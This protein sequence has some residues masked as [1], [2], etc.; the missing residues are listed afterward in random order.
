MKKLITLLLVLVGGMTQCWADEIKDFWLVGDFSS[1]W[2]EVTDTYKMST[3]DGNWYTL[4]LSDV[5]LTAKTYAFKVRDKKEKDWSGTSFGRNESNNQEF[6]VSTAGTYDLYFVADLSEKKVALILFNK[7]QVKGDFSSW[8]AVD[9]SKN[10]TYSYSYTIDLTD[11]STDQNFKLF[12]DAPGYNYGENGWID[13]AKVHISQTPTPLLVGEDNKYLIGSNLLKGFKKFV[14]TATWK[15]CTS[16]L[17]NWTITVTP[18][19]ERTGASKVIYENTN[20]WTNVWAFNWTDGVGNT[21]EW[22]GEHLTK[23]N[24]FYEYYYTTSYEKIIFN[25]G[26][27]GTKLVDQ[28]NDLSLVE[29][30]IY[31][32]NGL[33][34][35]VTIPFAD[36]YATFS[37]PYPLTFSESD[38]NVKAYKATVSDGKVVMS[39]VTGVVPA[40]TGLFVKKISDAATVTVSPAATATANMSGNLLVAG[41]DAGVAASTSGAYNYVFGKKDQDYGFFNVNVAISDDMTGKAYLSSTTALTAPNASRI[42]LVFDDETTGIEAIDV[43]PETVKEG[44]REYYNLNGQRVMNPG[45]GLYIVNGKKVIMK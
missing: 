28:T 38:A 36:K 22:P 15:E 35:D 7:L 16:I 40:N 39:V 18:S 42:A 23:V 33:K 6:T 45:K 2:D 44:A 5:T 20:G 32:I 26:A 41:T 8:A 30:G 43:T 21:A 27:S 24:G 17:Y 29:N 12:V 14:V 10:K 19:D 31:D 11:K 1:S 4:S 25:K 3:E 37:S 9:M 13:D 34:A